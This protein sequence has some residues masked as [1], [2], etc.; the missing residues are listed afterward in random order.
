LHDHD[1]LSRL[2]Q[3]QGRLPE[4]LAA[5]RRASELNPELEGLRR[6]VAD[7]ARQTGS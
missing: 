4:A 5:A 1:Q 7:L 6:R 3:Q 2:L